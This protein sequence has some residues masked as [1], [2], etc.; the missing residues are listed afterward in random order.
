MIS[1]WAQELLG[2]HFTVIHRPARM[3]RDV[4]AITRRFGPMIAR[5]MIIALI[6]S[7]RD[8]ATRPDAYDANTFGSS[9]KASSFGT[10]PDDNAT[11][12]DP[13]LI[14]KNIDHSFQQFTAE[15]PDKVEPQEA[16]QL[17]TSPIMM[18]HAAQS[19]ANNYQQRLPTLE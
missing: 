11:H 5:H 4:D 9:V 17:A 2:Y 16:L 10:G 3:M 8:K 18:I 1:R 13:V 15:T 6:L 12:D 19:A 14:T 7:A